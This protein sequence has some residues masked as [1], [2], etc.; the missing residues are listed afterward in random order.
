[1]EQRGLTRL[2]FPGPGGVVGVPGGDVPRQLALLPRPVAAGEGAGEGASRAAVGVVHVDL[3]AVRRAG[4][5]A[6]IRAGW[7]GGCAGA[8]AH[9][10]VLGQV[11]LRGWRSEDR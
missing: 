4:H 1:M 8:V 11:L 3:Q 2:P 7:E 10:H 9:S 5:I 6:T